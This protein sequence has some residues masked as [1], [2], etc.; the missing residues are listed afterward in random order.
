MLEQKPQSYA[1]NQCYPHDEQAVSRVSE[2]G[3]TKIDRAIDD[4]GQRIFIVLATVAGEEQVGY[5]NRND[6][7]HQCLAQVLSLDTTEQCLLHNNAC[8]SN[9]KRSKN[10]CKP[11]V[12]C[13]I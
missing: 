1:N 9:A 4:I 6:N 12:S 13:S 11:P 8:H 10:D 5:N 3:Y 7:G 2:T